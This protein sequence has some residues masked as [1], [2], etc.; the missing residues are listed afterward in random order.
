MAQG[1]SFRSGWASLLGVRE[2]A[3]LG[4]FVTVAA[5]GYLPFNSHS[6][7]LSREKMPVESLNGTRDFMMVVQGGEKVEGSIEFYA[8]AADD[9]V[10]RL[11]K[12]ALAGSVTSASVA[13]AGATC[14]QHT[15]YA[16]DGQNNGN[17]ASASNTPGLSIYAKYGETLT[18]AVGY[19]GC[20]VNSFSIKG[21]LGQPIVMT[22]ELVGMTGSITT[23]TH[24]TATFS[25]QIPLMFNNVSV[26]KADNIGSITSGTTIKVQSFEL[27]INNNIQ[28][29][30]A[31]G[32]LGSRG[33]TVLPMGRREISLKLS[34]R[35]D[36]T[37]TWDEYITAGDT[38][39]ALR[40][41]IDSG[42]TAGAIAGA[43]TYGMYFDL[44]FMKWVNPTPEVSGA[45]ILTQELEAK[46]YASLTVTNYAIRAVVYNLTANY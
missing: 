6:M 21:E 7:K 8:N 3:T 45:E 43:T 36:T 22:A 1:D 10:I 15:L 37:T 18:A 29:D 28:S 44:P 39:S 5:G 11:L 13:G 41:N 35:F 27:T 34:A 24:P 20:R 9:T 31:A 38:I 23:L 30:D 42:V 19:A 33:P 17:T 14:I 4:T 26:I 2:E 40:I 46:V 25:S 32:A 16:G 12:H